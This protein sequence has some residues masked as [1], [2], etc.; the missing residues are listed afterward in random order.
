MTRRE[1]RVGRWE[2]DALCRRY[3]PEGWFPV[4]DEDRVDVAARRVA[5]QQCNRSCTVKWECLSAVMSREWGVSKGYRHGVWG[6]TT[7]P[8]RI[9]FEAVLRKRGWKPEKQR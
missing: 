8:E 9:E 7:P 5:A 1:T 6:G 4:T 3:D 2:E